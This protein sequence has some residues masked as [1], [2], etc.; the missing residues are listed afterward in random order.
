MP[1]LHYDRGDLTQ[2]QSDF[3]DHHLPLGSRGC[4]GMSQG[5]VGFCKPGRAALWVCISASG[6]R[7]APSHS[8]YQQGINAVAVLRPQVLKL[9]L[10]ILFLLGNISIG[11]FKAHFLELLILSYPY[12]PLLFPSPTCLKL[13]PLLMCVLLKQVLFCV[14]V[15]LIYS[16][17]L[18]HRSHSAS[19]FQHV[20]FMVHPCCCV[21]T[22]D[23]CF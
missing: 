13:I 6:G 4:L 16:V 23:H 5:S 10:L 12:S 11:P 21:H 9:E 3:Q 8:H 2:G 1:Q 15:F 14:Q 7:K 18:C 22:P 20:V 17:I 19:Y